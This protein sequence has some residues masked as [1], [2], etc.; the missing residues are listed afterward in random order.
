M[1]KEFLAIDLGAESGRGIVGRYD[2]QTLTLTEV[3]RFATGQGDL[4][5]HSD[6]RRR[7]DFERIWSEIDAIVRKAEAEHGG[8]L[9]GVGVD[10]WGVD[11]GLVDSSGGLVISPVQY[12]DPTHGEARQR[13][14]ENFG[15]NS[16]WMQTGIQPMPFNTVFQLHARTNAEADALQQGA[17]LLLMPD[18]FHFMLTGGESGRHGNEL[19]MASTTQLLKSDRS[20]WHRE[21]LDQL[22]IPHHFLDKLHEAGTLLG[23]TSGGTPVYAPAT[24]DTASAVVA[25]PAKSG[26]NWAFLSS[27]TWSLL[28]AVLPNPILDDAALEAGFSNEGGVAGTTRFL[29]NIM[30]LW[31]VQECRRSLAKTTGRDY[32]YAELTEMAAQSA[33]LVSLVDATDDRFLAPADMPSEI[34]AACAETSQ[35]IPA[36][37]DVGALIRCCLDSLAFAYRRGIRQLSEL[38]GRK[39]DILHIIGGGSQNRLLNQLTADATGLTV[40]SGPAEATAIGNIIAQLVGSHAI[41]HWQAG[42]ELCRSSFPVETFAPNQANDGIWA[43]AENKL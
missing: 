40:I 39:F 12:R 26:E 14:F 35:P 13:I 2:G 37:G 34:L 24:H 19:T 6:G 5:I 7:W 23:K 43:S 10:S 17:Q 42:S 15:R 33:P 31:L 36:A 20:D 41:E 3:G 38:T 9:D 18:L 30:G 16:L 28:G 4:D 22:S 29:K 21:L 25:V 32:T 11:Y 27:G 1:D 8:P